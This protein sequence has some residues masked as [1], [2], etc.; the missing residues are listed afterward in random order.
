MSG[1]L[2]EKINK[3]NKTWK[4]IYIP[5]PYSDAEYAD[6]SVS[7]FKH[8]YK[9][10]TYSHVEKLDKESPFEQGSQTNNTSLKSVWLGGWI[11]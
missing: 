8:N 2:M 1:L 5:Q 3:I 6:F 10:L 7:V 11:C 4:P 9:F